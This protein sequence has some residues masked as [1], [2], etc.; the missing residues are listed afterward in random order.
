MNDFEKMSIRELEKM[1][2]GS[3]ELPEKHSGL[4]IASFV[5]SIA[6]GIIFI[7]SFIIM[8]TIVAIEGKIPEPTSPVAII[9]GLIM[10]LGFVGLLVGAGLGIAGLFEKNRKKIFSILGLIFNAGIFL[11]FIILMIIGL[12][13]RTPLDQ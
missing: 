1:A 12:L 9:S 4:G 11:V 6:V 2:T 5:I 7:L 8:G 13:T 3:G 10:M